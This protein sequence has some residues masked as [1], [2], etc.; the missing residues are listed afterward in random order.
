MPKSMLVC[1]VAAFAASASA[2]NVMPSALQRSQVVARGSVFM[3]DAEDKKEDEVIAGAGTPDKPYK[4][5][6]PDTSKMVDPWAKR[7]V[8]STHDNSR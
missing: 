5:P 4:S 3:A 8:A 1:G 6:A 2:L 7:V